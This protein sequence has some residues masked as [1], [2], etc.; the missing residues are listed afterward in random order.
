MTVGRAHR[1]LPLLLLA[2][3]L[4][5]LAPAA[6]TARERT[7]SGVVAD[8]PTGAQVPTNLR[9]RVADVLSG[10][11]PVLHSNRTHLIFWQPA[12]S[13]LRFE[14]GYAA[15]IKRFLR[16]VAA[17][18][19]RPGNIFGLTGQY[20]D[21]HGPAAY[22][23]TYAGAVLATDP[24]P[25]GGCVEPLPPQLGGQGPGWK[26]CVS[27]QQ[28][29]DELMRVVS[30]HRLPS[31]ATDVFL[32][33]TP[34]GLGDCFGSGPDGC[35]LGGL[36]ND[37]Y[38]G[39][40]DSTQ[41]GGVLYAVIPYNAVANHCQ[42]DNPRPN[43]S[44]A[45]PTIST[46]AHELAEIVTDPLGTSWFEPGQNGAGDVEIADLCLTRY[47]PAL[48]GAGGAGAYDQ[49]IHGGR[50]FI[51]EL[52]SNAD[53]RC[54]PAAQ[55]DSASFRAP[56]TVPGDRRCHAERRGA[57][58]SRPDRLLQ[59]VVRGSRPR[60]GAARLA[61]LC[62]QRPVQDRP[63]HDRQLGEP[64]RRLPHGHGHAPRSALDAHHG[65]TDAREQSERRGLPLQLR[66]R[67]R[68]LRLPGRSPGLAALPLALLDVAARPGAAQLRRPRAGHLRPARPPGRRL[69][70]RG[71]LG[72]GTATQTAAVA[73]AGARAGADPAVTKSGWAMFR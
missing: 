14:S 45:D 21:A 38:C 70:L 41:A 16:Q 26:A 64:R 40:H 29:Q 5:L 62:Q 49:V 59:L 52:W 30:A 36:G 7:A 20:G 37:G 31:S 54:L 23:S 1:V 24:L 13:G 47:G 18:S 27:D 58:C 57:R 53:G 48:G 2:L 67:D 9:A 44:P 3:A 63:A 8:V 19:R 34:E 15:L 65:R 51:Q 71:R 11:G 61:R 32:I 72:R 73:R 6:S 33:L 68:A 39:Y 22:D 66:C 35:A 42:S 17:D 43:S 55:A 46:L 50:Y 28:L 4:A 56:A 60:R 10:G 25:P 12:G 69:R